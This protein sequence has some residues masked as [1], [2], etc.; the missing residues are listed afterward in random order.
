[1]CQVF[2]EYPVDGYQNVV[3]YTVLGLIAVGMVFDTKCDVLL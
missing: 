1:M 3:L 2:I